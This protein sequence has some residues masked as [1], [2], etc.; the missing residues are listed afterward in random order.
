M[1]MD[2]GGRLADYDYGS[3]SMFSDYP[4]S[5][6]LA[7]S[8][9]KLQ[10]SR[11]MLTESMEDYLEMIYRLTQ[12]KGYVRAVD[13]AEQLKVQASSVTRMVQKLHEADFVYYEKYRNIGLTPSGEHYGRFLIWR[14]RVL[15]DFL[16]LLDA[17]LGIEEQVEGM[18]HYITPTTMSLIRNLIAFFHC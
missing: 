6:D 3:S 10:R 18:E 17:D 9:V 11:I 15:K 14:D 8:A 5:Q 4:R 1:E 16:R 2:C 7:V 12:A 13:L